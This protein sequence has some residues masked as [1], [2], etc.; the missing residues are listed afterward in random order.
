[1]SARSTTSCPAPACAALVERRADRHRAR[2][3]RARVRALELRSVQ[4]GVRASRA[5]SSATGRR[6]RRSPRPIY[7]QSFDLETGECLD[8]PDCPL[9]T[10][11]VRVV[12]GRVQVGV[13]YPVDALMARRRPREPLW[14]HSP[15][16]LRRRSPSERLPVLSV[17]AL[18]R[19]AAD[20]DRGR[21]LRAHA[22]RT[23]DVPASGASTTASSSRSSAPTRRSAVRVRGRPRRVHRLQGLRHRL[24]QPERA[25]RRRGLAHGRPAARRHARTL[26][27]SRPSPPLP[28]LRRAGLHARLPG[29]APTKR[30]P[31]PASSSTST[32]SASVA[33]TARSCARTT[34]RSTTRRAASCASATCAATASRTARRRPACRRARTRR[35]RFASSTAAAIVEAS[36]ARQFLARRADARAHA[37]DDAATR[38]S[39]ALPRNMLPADFYATSPEHSHPPLVVMLTLTQLSVGA[40]VV[41]AGRSSELRGG[42]AGSPLVADG[43]SRSRSP[44]LALGGE[45]VSPGAAAARVARGP[46]PSHLV[47]EPRSARLRPVRAARRRLRARSRL[48]CCRRC[49]ARAPSSSAARRSCDRGA[50]LRGRRRRLLLGDGLRR[51]AARAVVGAA[52]RRQVLRHHGRCSAAP[53]CWP[54]PRAPARSTPSR[55]GVARSWLVLAA[56]AR[57]A[58][59]RGARSRRTRTTSAVG[60]RSAWPSSCSAICARATV[61]RFALLGS[62]AAS[63][64]RS[65]DLRRSTRRLRRSRRAALAM[66]VAAPRGELAERYLFFRPRPRRACPAGSDDRTLLR[67]SDASAGPARRRD[68]P[69]H[70]RALARARAVRPRPRA[71]A[72]RADQTTDDGVR[73]L[74]DGLRPRRSCSRTARPSGS[75]PTADYPVNLGMACPKGW[76]ALTPLRGPGRATTPLVATERPP[77]RRRPGRTPRSRWSTASRPSR[78]KHGPASVAWLGTGQMP[79]E[80]LALPRRARQVRHGHG[81]RR[82]Q[83]APVH[84]HRRGRLQ[85]VVRLRRAAVHLRRLRGVRRHRARRLEPVHRASDHVGA[86]LQEP[87]PARDHRHRPAQDRDGD[88]GDAA[89]RRQ[90][91]VRSRRSS[92]ALAHVLIDKG[93]I[94]R[95][96]H[97]RAHQRLRRV[98]ARTWRRSRS[99]GPPSD[100]ASP[101]REIDALARLI[102]EGKRVSFWWTMGVNQSHEGV[103][104]AQAIIDL[105]LDDRQHRA[106]RHRRELDHR[107][108]QRDGLA[109][110]QQHDQPA[111]R[112]RL[113]ERR[114]PR[115]GRAHPRHRRR[116]ASRASRASPTTRSSRG[117]SRARSAALWV[118]ATNPAHSWINQARL[119]TTCSATRLPRRAGHVPRHRDGASSRDIVLP[120][121]GWGEKEGTFINSERRIGVVKRVCRAPGQALADFHIFQ[122]RRR[123][124]GMRRAVPRW[125]SPGGG[126]SDPEAAEPRAARAT[127][128]AS[129]TTWPSIARGGIQWPLPG[130]RD[131]RRPSG[132]SSTTVVFFTPDGK[133]RS[134]STSRGRC[135]SRRAPTTR[136][137]LLT[138]RGSSSQWHTQTRTKRSAVLAAARA[139]RALRRDLRADASALGIE[140]N[141]IVRVSSQRGSVQARAFVTHSVQAGSGLHARCTTT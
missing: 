32:T 1:M 45:R 74:L 79:T 126:V 28:P 137:C 80:E 108:V 95:D 9:A 70:P 66:L 22:R 39:S 129:T 20:P 69:L 139:D 138:G 46:R 81:P 105:A 127:S 114:R 60:A 77:R 8:D 136:S 86:H 101:P 55:A 68:G 115:R 34:R 120:A 2:A 84:G 73:L 102:H 57:Q 71:R 111:R 109:A 117:S 123:G 100:R 40:F 36:E 110:L 141:E 5:A 53:R 131:D 21:A 44:S 30:I 47:A 23:R 16:P 91:E 125:S 25:R 92:T 41:G 112:A 134:S 59:L 11:P 29:A 56:A 122:L 128:P 103:R 27:R 98:R 6:R 75:T 63:S 106:A 89:L 38:R 72:P 62:R 99:S 132:A 140:P 31:S 26:R 4:Q 43:C 61:L 87:A 65:L 121:A 50:A 17:A 97:R 24:P 93:W 83:H 12:D 82:R 7:K 19:R 13:P 78:Q 37:A 135:P 88:G 85:A 130:R 90:A 48:P 113:H 116:A 10:Y 118:V 3:R 42:P 49:P 96:V 107:A 15:A 33:S 67:R 58:R 54:W 94:D 14:R 133:A 35:S 119:R 51:D 104:T 76:E 64:C 18:A 52:H 124:L